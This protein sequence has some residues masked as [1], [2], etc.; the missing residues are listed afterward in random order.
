MGGCI[1]PATITKTVDSKGR[2]NLGKDF[3]N[4][5]VIITKE[6]DK[7]T[8]ELA[9]VIPAREVWLYKNP[10]AKAS[11]ERGLQQARARKFSQSP[12]DLVADA[13]LVSGLDED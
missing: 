7:I 4:Q 13:A 3:A 2:I 6:S 1:M 11:L 8:I 10:K 12:P 5:T 9:Q